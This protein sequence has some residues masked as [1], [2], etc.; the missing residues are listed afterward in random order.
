MA[1]QLTG[2]ALD[3]RVA[4]LMGIPVYLTLEEMRRNQNPECYPWL[5]A[6]HPTDGLLLWVA[7]E[8][9]A[10]RFHP[11]TD[12][13]AADMVR[14]WLEAQGCV[15]EHHSVLFG[16]SHRRWLTVIF[17]GKRKVDR[18][19]EVSPHEALCLAAV[20]LGEGQKDARE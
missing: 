11:S 6:Y 12:P 14:V 18:R 10:V 1:E 20:A 3:A 2:R 5:Q 15:L 8:T 16:A 4:E 17:K 13:A 9:D 7:P 19:S